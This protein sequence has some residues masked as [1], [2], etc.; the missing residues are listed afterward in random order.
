MEVDGPCASRSL[1]TCAK[2]HL[3]EVKISY[4]ELRDHLYESMD[5]NSDFS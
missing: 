4:L 5:N 3:D 2:V 1:P